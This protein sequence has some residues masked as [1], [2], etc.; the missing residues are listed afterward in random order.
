MSFNFTVA[1]VPNN[2]N[3][4]TELQYIKS[5]LLYAD[6]I[7]LISPIAYL[8]T[9]ITNDMNFK[10]ERDA[11]ESI[12]RIIPFIKSSNGKTYSELN[13]YMSECSKILFE[14]K[15][16][17]PMKAK[18][19][20]RNVLF[21]GALDAAT[22]LEGNIGLSQCQELKLLLASKKLKLSPFKHMISD[23]DEVVPEYFRML[24]DA[25]KNSY[26]IFDSISNEVMRTAVNARVVNLS[27]FDKKKIQHAGVSDNLLQ[28]LPN[29]SDASIDEIIDIRNDLSIPLVRFRSQMLKF[30]D[31]IQSCPWDKDFE[32]EC[33]QLYAKEIAPAIQEIDELTKDASFVKNLARN[34]LVDSNLIKSASGLI[35]SI[36][37]A[38]VFSAY[39]NVVSSGIAIGTATLAW[40]AEKIAS[41]YVKMQDSNKEITKKDL[42]FYYQ[43]GN[44]LKK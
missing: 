38:G 25:I 26:P 20:L 24:T 21:R 16:T 22:I 17:V 29:F 42:Y 13:A 11:Y 15:K 1:V 19:Q 37:A 31:D 34:S 18:M 4:N 23:V 41:T 27:E 35:I 14:N 36:A 5:A 9:L 32:F 43:A 10:N 40:T 3:I 7:T 28:K 2:F 12:K 33:I 8:Y 6:E 39:S 30:S 44:L